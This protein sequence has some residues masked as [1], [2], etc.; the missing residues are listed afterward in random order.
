MLWGWSPPITRM[1]LKFDRVQ[2]VIIFL[3]SNDRS[4]DQGE[5]KRSHTGR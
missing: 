3:Q 1:V 4:D 5:G 2:I